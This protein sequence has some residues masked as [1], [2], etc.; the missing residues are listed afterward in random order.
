MHYSIILLLQGFVS[1]RI[2]LGNSLKKG[3][4]YIFMFGFQKTKVLFVH[5][6]WK[7]L[8]TGNIASRK[9]LNLPMISSFQSTVTPFQSHKP[10][11]LYLCIIKLY[12]YFRVLIF[13]PDFTLFANCWIICLCYFHLCKYLLTGYPVIYWTI[14]F[15]LACMFFHFIAF[16]DTLL[17]NSL[18]RDLSLLSWSISSSC[19]KINALITSIKDK[20]CKRFFKITKIFMAT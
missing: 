6:H 5:A 11:S 9:K 17:K 10:A 18:Q 20:G 13:L 2:R 19:L 16:K 15:Y 14:P 8:V 7:V 3:R 12:V 1:A 4:D